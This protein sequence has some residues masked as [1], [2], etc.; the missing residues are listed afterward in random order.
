MPFL[1]L[2]QFLLPLSPLL[3]AVNAVATT[4]STLRY[5]CHYNFVAT[6]AFT[7]TSTTL[8]VLRFILPLI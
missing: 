2:L 6:A 1:D 8:D 7:T 4:V 3:Q 5:C